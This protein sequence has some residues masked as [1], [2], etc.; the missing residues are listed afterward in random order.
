MKHRHS[1]FAIFFLFAILFYSFAEAGAPLPAVTITANDSTATEAGP[2]TGQFTVTRTGNTASALTVYFT[3]SGTATSGSDYTS[4]GTSVTIPK[5]SASV[6]KTVTPVNDTLVESNET[7]VVTLS[8]NAAYTVGS[9]SSATVTI[10]SDDV[11]DTTPPTT[12]SNLSSTA[13]GCS[14]INLSWSP[15]TDTG[16]SGLA[17]YKVYRGGSYMGSTTATNYSDYSCAASTQYCYRVTA[18]DNAGNESGQCTQA[19]ATTQSGSQPGAHIW[20]ERFGGTSN[21]FGRAVKADSIGNLIVAGRFMGT[22][23]FGG[24]SLTNIGSSSL[25]VA[26]YTAEGVHQWSKAYGGTSSDV[27]VQNIALDSSGNVVVIGYFTGAV[28]FGGG[29]LTSAGGNDIFLAKYSGATGAHVW[30]KRFGNTQ[31]DAGY[32]VAVDEFGNVIVT[33]GFKGSVDFG[34]GALVAYASSADFFVAKYTASGTHQWSKRVTNT[35]DD[36]GYSVVTDGSG[37]ILLTGYFSG[38]IDFGGGVLTSAGLFDIFVVKYSGAG[39]HVWSKRLGS[40]QDDFGYGIDVDG[41]G[42]VMVTGAFK[43]SVD[44]GGGLLSSVALQDIFLAKYSGTDGTHQWSRRFGG[45]S[46]DVVNRIAVDENGDLVVTGYFQVYGGF[47][48][49]CT[50]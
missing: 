13:A 26:K 7:V 45:S 9:P 43:G 11:T 24:G 3:V 40:T 19:C 48:G 34:G 46:D 2:T 18:Y 4:I 30:S 41:S 5:K 17:G 38:K 32:G 21:D 1:F 12:P 47:W 6:V 42:N 39:T 23:D 20:S 16:G 33:G 22:V 31:D 15:S 36:Y 29:V 25:F 44:F 37:D 50:D 10:T 49:R 14:L 35:G 8:S 27:I 28:N